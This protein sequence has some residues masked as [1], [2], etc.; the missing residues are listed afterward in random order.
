MPGS[1]IHVGLEGWQYDQ[2]MDFSVNGNGLKFAKLSR[3]FP[4]MVT[5]KYRSSEQAPWRL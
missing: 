5:L 2:L 4:S 3:S 1:L